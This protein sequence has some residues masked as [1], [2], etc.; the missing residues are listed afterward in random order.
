MQLVS[1]LLL[2]VLLLL[3]AHEKITLFLVRR[4]EDLLFTFTSEK[5]SATVVM[6][7][8]HLLLFDFNFLLFFLELF[9]LNINHYQIF[10]ERQ[11]NAYH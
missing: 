10:R 8:H 6:D 7:L 4:L 11:E 3:E 2:L 1:L 5:S 9:I